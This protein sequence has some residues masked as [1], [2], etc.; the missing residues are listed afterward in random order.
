VF[1]CR[2]VSPGLGSLFVWRLGLRRCPALRTSDCPCLSV[3]VAPGLA[4]L[5][6]ATHERRCL[7]TARSLR[8]FQ[9]ENPCRSRQV[10][11]QVSYWQHPSGR[12]PLS[13]A[14]PPPSFSSV[15]VFFIRFRDISTEDTTKSR[16][17]VCTCVSPSSKRALFPASKSHGIAACRSHITYYTNTIKHMLQTYMN[18]GHELMPPLQR[19][20]AVHLQRIC[21]ACSLRHRALGLPV[22]S[23]GLMPVQYYTCCTC[24]SHST[25]VQY[26]A[27]LH[28]PYM[29]H[30]F[31]HT[32]ITR[33]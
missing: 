1:V 13:L 20:M 25:F 31:I 26:H 18:H 7:A 5:P 19:G 23:S 4:A 14:P 6:G 27:T 10:L 21:S 15:V 2:A 8:F 12:G 17:D 9:T 3:R 24:T 22:N 29:Q 28:T 11:N 32:Y 16:W 33:T 30:T